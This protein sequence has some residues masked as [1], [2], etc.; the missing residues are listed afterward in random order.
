MVSYIIRRLGGSIVVLLG[1]ALITFILSYAVPADPA[2][3]IL[4]MKASAAQVAA[5]RVHMG[6]NLPLPEQFWNYLV[7]LLHGNLGQSYI[8]DLPV[9][10]LIAQRVGY[11]AQLALAAWLMELVIGI[12]IG[13]ISALKDRK[14]TDHIL[15]IVALIGISLPVFFVGLELMYWLAFKAGW[16]PVGGTG[17][18]PY[19]ILPALAYG[20]TGAA[21]YA[22]LLKSSMLDVLNSDYIRTARAKGASSFRAV[23]GH[24]LRNAMIP[25]VTYGATDVAALF[26]GVVVLEDVFGYAG[27][28][29]M[30]VQAINQLDIP[31]IMGTVLFAAVF[32]VLFNLIVDVLYGF[33]DPRITY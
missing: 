14:L 1:I 30:A 20:I 19:I 4:G 22:R 17:G 8:L 24:A 21:Y 9:T 2:R 29:Q 25:V 28:G 27:M 33:I 11:T 31:L 18:L 16:F 7:K 10:T 13:I 5:L 23:M 6:L 12:P 3:L 15:S 26:G 32:V